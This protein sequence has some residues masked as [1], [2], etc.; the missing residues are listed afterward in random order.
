MR[1]DYLLMGIGLVALVVM[2]L[3]LV[4]LSRD[5]DLI[6]TDPCDICMNRTNAYCYRIG[7]GD[8]IHD[9]IYE[10]QINN[11]NLKQER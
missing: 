10:T 4:T 1:A 11:P 3:A 9:P 6:K 8:P 5:I 7:E 2:I